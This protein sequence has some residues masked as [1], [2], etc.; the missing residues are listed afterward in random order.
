MMRA[1]AIVIGLMLAAGCNK[2]ESDDCRKAIKNMNRLMGTD[3]LQTPAAV[4]AAVRSCRGTSTKESVECA[5]QA[6]TLDQLKSCGFYKEPKLEPEGSGSA[7]GSG[8]AGS[9][10]AK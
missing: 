4:E 5:I 7:A 8:S 2:P 9:G 6:Q 1:I 3:K 10:S